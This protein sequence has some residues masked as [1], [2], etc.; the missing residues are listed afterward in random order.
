MDVKKREGRN[1]Q[2]GSHD[3]SK[4]LAS[5]STT[6]RYCRSSAS[7]LPRALKLGHYP[8]DPGLGLAS[9]EM[10][11]EVDVAGWFQWGLDVRGS[12]E[13]GDENAGV[14]ALPG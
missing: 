5:S 10:E 3:I 6:P 14:R 11:V 2:K 12:M 13:L 4:Y 1:M 8:T 7:A 9:W